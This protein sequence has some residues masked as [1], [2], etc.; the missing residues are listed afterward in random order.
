MQ[1]NDTRSVA[2]LEAGTDQ[3][4]MGLLLDGPGLWSVDETQ[5]EIGGNPLLVEDGLN[6]LHAA[7][8]VHRLDQFV[9]ATR[10]ATKAAD[11]HEG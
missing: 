8:M 10:T 5:R 11:L 1:G 6:R 7:G 4:I 3:A 2:E 9:F